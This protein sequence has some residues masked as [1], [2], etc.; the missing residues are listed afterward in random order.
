MGIA[1]L[2]TLTVCL[3]FTL[4]SQIVHPGYD[5]IHDAIS[6]LVWGPGGWLQTVSFSLLGFSVIVLGVKLFFKAQAPIV[7][8]IGSIF[9]ML[10]GIGTIMVSFFP[11]DIPGSLTTLTG[12]IHIHTAESLVI[13]F[14][15][16]CLLMAPHMKKIFTRQW[17]SRYTHLAAG[18]SVALIITVVVMVLGDHGFTGTLERLIMANGLAWVQLMHIQLL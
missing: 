9:L 4:I 5:P 3:L 18:M 14:P 8:K 1:A 11:T 10:M 13:L 12:M 15:A 16:A 2:I 17:I 6:V 7:Y